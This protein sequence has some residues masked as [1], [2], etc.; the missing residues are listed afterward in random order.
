MIP[1]W[2]RYMFLAVQAFL[3]RTC[4]EQEGHSAYDSRRSDCK[5]RL[6]GSAQSASQ[7]TV[8]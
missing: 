8:L 6:G 1:D 5:I 2:T 7:A 3:S 4:R